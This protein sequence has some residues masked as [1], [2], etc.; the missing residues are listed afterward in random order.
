MRL[1]EP[2]QGHRLAARISRRGRDDLRVV[3]LNAV[4]GA[5]HFIYPAQRLS[6]SA[7]VKALYGAFPTRE[8][9]PPRRPKA[10]APSENM[11]NGTAH[12]GPQQADPIPIHCRDAVPGVRIG[13]C[14][15]KISAVLREY[16]AQPNSSLSQ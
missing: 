6:A 4:A 2:L 16:P 5:P 15:L 12:F 8:G 11:E 1:N 9:R 7:R 14:Q 10:L 3:R 13:P